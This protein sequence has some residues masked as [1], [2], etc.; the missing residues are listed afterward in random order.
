MFQLSKE[1]AARQARLAIDAEKARQEMVTS[2]KDTTPP[3]NP[4][5]PD[6]ASEFSDRYGGSLYQADNNNPTLDQPSNAQLEKRNYRATGKKRKKVGILRNDLEADTLIVKQQKN[7]GFAMFA[8]KSNKSEQIIPDD[9]INGS[10]IEKKG[11]ALGRAAAMTSAYVW[12]NFIYFSVQVWLSIISVIAIG[13]VFA[14]EYYVG[15][16]MA[17]DTFKEMI[18][19]IGVNWDF[20]LVA[21]LFY[22]LAVTACYVQLFGVAIQAKALGLHPLGGEGSFFKTATFLLCFILYWVPIVNCLPLV[23]FYILS[24]QTYPR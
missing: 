6:T 4:L 13:I 9:I 3:E 19:A 18:D 1:E 21:L 17:Q 14:I 5:H 10:W 22:M 15:S 7:Q 23:N 2:N 20:H 11:Y 8:N 12:T 24:I 16:G